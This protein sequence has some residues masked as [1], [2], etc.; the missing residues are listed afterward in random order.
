MNECFTRIET[1]PQAFDD[2]RATA[3]AVYALLLIGFLGF[4]VLDA[5]EYYSWQTSH[6]GHRK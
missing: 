4:Q 3:Q 6:L 2:R 5:T 1:I